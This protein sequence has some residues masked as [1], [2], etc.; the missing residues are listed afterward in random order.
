MKTSPVIKR[1]LRHALPVAFCLAAGLSTRAATFLY[2]NVDLIAG[3]RTVGG[4]SDL[5]VNLG[6]AANLENLPYG[7][8]IVQTNLQATQ[9]SAAF[10]S[11]NNVTWSVC[12]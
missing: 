2:T 4:V 5:V 7:T 11:L 9:L 8:S 12:G 6:S 1:T 3:F 10:A